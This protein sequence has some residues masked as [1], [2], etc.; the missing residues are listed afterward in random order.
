MKIVCIGKNYLKHAQ[1]MNS[2]VPKEPLVFIKPETALNNGSEVPYPAFT[3][4]LHYELELVLRIGEKASNI[5][6]SDALKIVDSYSLGIDF[7]ARDLQAQFKASGHP[8]EKSKAF[9]N[10][11]S[12]GMMKDYNSEDLDALF[13]TLELND[14]IVQRG[15]TSKMIFDIKTIISYSSSFFTLSPGDLIFTGTPEGVGAVNKGDKLKA[16]LAD[17]LLLDINII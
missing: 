2:K 14:T 5:S 16:Y 3:N 10:S 12:I 11:A 13:F 17:E 4:D 1:E 15:D 7:T 6:K 9:D 8:W